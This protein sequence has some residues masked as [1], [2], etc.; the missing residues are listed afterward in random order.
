[1]QLQVTVA[2]FPITH[3]SPWTGV[4]TLQASG[5]GGIVIAAREL[6]TAEMARTATLSRYFIVYGI[7]ERGWEDE[8]GMYRG[9]GYTVLK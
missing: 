6:T 2:V 9:G 3:T 1:L 8:R 4:T 7:T 5:G